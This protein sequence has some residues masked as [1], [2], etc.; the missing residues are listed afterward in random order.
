[1]K[2]LL[3]PTLF[4]LSFSAFADCPKHKVK[5]ESQ[6]HQEQVVMNASDEEGQVSSEEM[7]MKKHHSHSSRDRFPASER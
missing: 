2:R 1:M 6:S 4:A 3:F 5:A 7:K